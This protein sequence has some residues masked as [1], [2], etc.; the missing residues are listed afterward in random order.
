MVSAWLTRIVPDTR[1]RAARADLG[2][3][4]GMHR[5]LMSLLPDSLGNQARAQTGLLFRIDYIR[6]G[7]A[8]ILV[9]STT[10]PDLSQLPAGYGTAD[11]KPLDPLLDAIGEG[12]PVRFRL[13]ANASK[14][15][16]KS[17]GHHNAGQVVALGGTDAEDWWRKR[18]E[19][20]HRLRIVVLRSEAGTAARGRRGEGTVI[21]AVTRFDGTALVTDPAAVRQAVFTGI[22]RGKAYGCG[23]LSI[24]PAKNTP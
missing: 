3:P 18:A 7:A 4:V 21:H 17:D 16:W 1:A 19:E 13:A 12:L 14:R 15:L 11:Q 6:T 20:R 8:T 10:Q 22:G 2:D 24:A 5:R 23:L 9:Q